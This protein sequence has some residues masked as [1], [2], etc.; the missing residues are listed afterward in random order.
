M[1]EV[2]MPKDVIESSME[3]S[4]SAQIRPAVIAMIV[5]TVLTGVVY[6]LC[7][8]GAAQLLFPWQANGSLVQSDGSRATDGKLAGS[9]LIGQ[10]FDDPRYFWGRVSATTPVPY[11]AA[12]S[13]GSNLGPTNPALLDALRARVA[14]LRAAS[15]GG[16]SSIP[17]DLVTSSASGLDPHISPAAAAWQIRRVAAARGIAVADLEELVKRHIER[18]QLG[19]LGEPR[20]NVLLLNLALDRAWPLRGT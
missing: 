5:L 20:V 13:G 1:P 18:R 15:G 7:V 3:N 2:V 10:P 12:S 6:P 8:T 19:I 11:N 17:V 14:R 4:F 9:A 16:A